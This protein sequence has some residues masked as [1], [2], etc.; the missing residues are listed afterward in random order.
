VITIYT[1][2]NCPFC[3]AAKDLLKNKGVS[4]KEIDVSDDDDFDALV[5]RTG[6]KT[7]PQ[8]FIGNEMIGG[9]RELTG[10]DREGK[11][12]ALLKKA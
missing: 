5:E 8:I 10:L 7:V 11:L 9:Y 2:S 1:T 6:W 3:H 12:D 4:F